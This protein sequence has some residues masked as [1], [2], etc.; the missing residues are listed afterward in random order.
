VTI[1]H[2]VP[3]FARRV[4]LVLA[5]VLVAGAGCAYDWDLGAPAAASSSSSGGGAGGSDAGAE[6]GPD[7]AALGAA[8]DAARDGA[9]LCTIGAAGQCG[10]SIVDER[11]CTSFVKD[12]A[13]AAAADFAEAVGSFEAAGCAP[14]GGSCMPGTTG[15]CLYNAGQGPF[16]L[17]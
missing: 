9:K 15:T 17:P 3:G 7:C 1:V 2:H 6:A 11:G 16:C 4:P 12:G 10:T 5:A 14:P 8:V 13:S